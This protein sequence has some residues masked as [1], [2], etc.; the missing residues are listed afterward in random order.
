MCYK[1]R[2]GA[3]MFSAD[4]SK[5]FLHKFEDFN[6]EFLSIRIFLKFYFSIA[7]GG[8]ILYLREIIQKISDKKT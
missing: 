3:R 6:S 8:S 1:E 7:N 2:Q 4:P 5:I